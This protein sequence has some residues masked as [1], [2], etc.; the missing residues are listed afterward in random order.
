MND[1]TALGEAIQSSS[2]GAWA[3]GD[4]YPFANLVHILGLVML[5]GGIGVLDLRLMGLF[6]RIPVTALAAAVTP[7]AVAGLALMIP[8][9][10]MMFAS[11]AS[12]L[13]SSFTFRTKLLL[14]ALALANAIAFRVV[15]QKQIVQWDADP[16]LGGRIMASA[17]LLLWLSVAGAGR[18]IA[19]S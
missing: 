10:A 2:F 6:R 19:Y 8:S 15:W 1:L 14:I 16:P 11:D 9:G 18:W 17:S 3:G 7:I 13:V 4:A 12:T 5:V